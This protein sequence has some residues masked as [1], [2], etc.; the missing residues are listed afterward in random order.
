MQHFLGLPKENKENKGKEKEIRAG[1]PGKP[2]R[3]FDGLEMWESLGWKHT[4]LNI[5]CH[6][7]QARSFGH[8]LLVKIKGGQNPKK[9]QRFFEVIMGPLLGCLF[10]VNHVSSKKYCA[11]HQLGAC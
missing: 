1:R 6:R 7:N 5:F 4:F 9:T 11:S 8:S 3:F 2:G 10:A